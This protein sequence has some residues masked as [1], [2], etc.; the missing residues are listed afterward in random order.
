[1]AGSVLFFI[2][3]DSRRVYL[4]GVSAQPVAEGVVQ[5][6]RNLSFVLAERAQ[7]VRFLVQDRDT[8]FTTNFDDV[9]RSDGTEIIWTPVRAPR[10]NAVAERF[11]STARRAA[12][13]PTFRRD[14]APVPRSARRSRP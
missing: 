3:L 14:L 8:K 13:G 6:A 10:A 12:A 2:E 5:Q 4:A 1:L 11:A 9:F 7:P